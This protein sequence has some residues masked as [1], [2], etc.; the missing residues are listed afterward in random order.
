M[1]IESQGTK[2]FFSTSTAR[3]TGTSA[4]IGEVVDWNGPDGAANPI[5]ITHLQSTFHEFMMGLGDEGNISLSVNFNA[6]DAGQS[7]LRTAR[8]NRYKRKALVK[9]NT[10]AT[11][12]TEFDAYCLNY[13]V[14][15]AVDDKVSGSIVLKITGKATYSTA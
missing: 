5:D 1:A 2:L 4:L 12:C 15:G 13:N 14:S 7:N 11:N 9:Y 6:T 3:S 8:A 10:T